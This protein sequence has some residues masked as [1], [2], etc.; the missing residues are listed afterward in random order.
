MENCALTGRPWS[1]V[2]SGSE[3]A[4]SSDSS[5]VLGGS[6]ATEGVRSALAQLLNLHGMHVNGLDPPVGQPSS[7]NSGGKWH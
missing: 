3:S 6:L 5:R 4:A 1:D 2:G 7:Q